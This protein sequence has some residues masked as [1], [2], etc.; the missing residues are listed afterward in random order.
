VIP[1]SLDTWRQNNVLANLVD[2]LVHVL[3]ET[4]RALRSCFLGLQLLALT[5][6]GVGAGALVLSGFLGR[7]LL[8]FLRLLSAFPSAL[9]R[10]P[11]LLSNL[12]GAPV[13]GLGSSFL[14]FPWAGFF[15][16]FGVLLGLRLFLLRLFLLRRFL[17]L[18]HLFLRRLLDFFLLGASLG[19]FSSFS[20]MSGLSL[21][22][23]FAWLGS[24]LGRASGLGSG[25]GSAS[26]RVSVQASVRASV[27]AVR[28][29]VPALRF[30]L[31]SGFGSVGASGVSLRS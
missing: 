3:G 19:F 18:R 10:V 1:D 23:G 21:G 11:A 24:G 27:R 5:I 25:F 7:L 22:S 14:G 28:L 13:V 2:N 31:T 8:R 6:Q 30:G 26:A 12:G 29:S 9:S 16:T 20:A 4:A 17:W 15:L